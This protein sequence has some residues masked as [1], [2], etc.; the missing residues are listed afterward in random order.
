MWFV[1]LIE[2]YTNCWRIEKRNAAVETTPHSFVA[3]IS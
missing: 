1:N 3:V 2:N